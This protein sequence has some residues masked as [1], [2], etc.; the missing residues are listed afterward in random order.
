MF[1][2]YRQLARSVELP[3][4]EEI[5]ANVE[6]LDR[7]IQC[8]ELYPTLYPTRTSASAAQKE[9]CRNCNKTR[10]GTL[11]KSILH[12]ARS[13]ADDWTINQKT[14]QYINELQNQFLSNTPH[15]KAL[16]MKLRLPV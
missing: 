16:A 10:F 6:A 3:A 11:E 5:S 8:A 1:S 13:L 15:Y 2:Y 9:F 4:V 14:V 12:H 7:C